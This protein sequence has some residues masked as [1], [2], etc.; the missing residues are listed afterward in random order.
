MITLKVFVNI[1]GEY[2]NPVGIM[3]DEA[4]AISKEVRQQ[5]AA[6]SGYSEIVFIDDVKAS[7]V[8]IF[9]PTSEVHFAGHALLGVIYYLE[10]LSNTKVESINCLGGHVSCRKDGDI[11]WLKADVSM[12][13]NWHLEQ[14][15][16]ASAVEALTVA[17][18][19]GKEHTYCWAWIDE[20]AG[21]VRAR[22]FAPDW[23][24]P[25]DEANGSGTMKVAHTLG[26]EIIVTHGQGSE[27]YSRPTTG[28]RIEV[29]GRVSAD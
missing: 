5:M 22:T 29:G 9:N 16:S 17:N 15:D 12:L 24:I 20:Q 21:L 19:A 14:Q 11:Y 18:T 3:L 13:P 27:I 6:D 7:K 23:G 25:E 8:S 2:G 10:Q 4:G 1:K 26:R 28:N